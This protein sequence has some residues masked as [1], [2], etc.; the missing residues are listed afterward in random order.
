MNRGSELCEHLGV[1]ECQG[2]AL[3]LNVG[4]FEDS[5]EATGAETV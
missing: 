2:S 1:A 4:V 3:R 5:K